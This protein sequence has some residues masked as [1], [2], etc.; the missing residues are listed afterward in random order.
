MKPLATITATL[1]HRHYGERAFNPST[2]K[3]VRD[4]TII[5]YADAS[6]LDSLFRYLN[7]TYLA[8]AIGTPARLIIGLANIDKT[9]TNTLHEALE[10]I[11]KNLRADTKLHLHAACHIKLLAHD[12]VAWLGSQNVTRGAEPWFSGISWKTHFNRN[13][14]AL[15]KVD[16]ADSEW[17]D[18]LCARVL[19]DQALC[20]QVKK[21]SLP[22]EVVRTLKRASTVNSTIENMIAGQRLRELLDSPLELVDVEGS[23]QSPAEVCRALYDIARGHFTAQRV[24]AL[25]EEIY[26]DKGLEN[27][28]CNNTYDLL[29]I[30]SA[31]SANIPACDAFLKVLEESPKHAEETEKELVE[32]IQ[33]LAQNY[34]LDDLEEFLARQRSSII[35]K[36]MQ[37]PDSSD[38][39]LRGAIDNDGSIN[40]E[41]LDLRLSQTSGSF[42]IPA[43]YQLEHIDLGPILKDLD[44]HIHRLVKQ[45]WVRNVIA[46]GR[47]LVKEIDRL[48]E[49]ELQD[50]EFMS[51]YNKLLADPESDRRFYI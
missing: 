37:S 18:D 28:K 34:G 3:S 32:I 41:L 14:E 24:S 29:E 26:G 38:S 48:Y 51:V 45:N 6:N 23:S 1:F 36:I 50:R 49:R 42:S 40:A 25:L 43:H 17:I 7:S 46:L 2:P 33:E 13:H 27:I 12:G 5:T 20:T 16:P 44:K 30:S 19:D 8:R 22:S 21:D 35:Q 10:E 39:Y 47:D 15:I 11:T 4:L 31:I 9:A